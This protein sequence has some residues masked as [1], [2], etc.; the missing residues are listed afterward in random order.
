MTQQGIELSAKTQN[1]PWDQAKPLWQKASLD[2]ANG[3]KGA[4]HVFQ[5]AEK[6]VNI[7]SIWA[8][9]EYKALINNPG[10]PEII[11]HLIMPDGSIKIFS[12]L[13]K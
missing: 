2:F 11:Y 3:A 12:Q 1:M 7:D 5:V 10:V 8:T 4:V 6:G 9:V 13:I